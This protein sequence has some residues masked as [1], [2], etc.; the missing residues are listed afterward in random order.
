MANTKHRSDRDRTLDRFVTWG[1]I[2]GALLGI[3]VFVFVVWQQVVAPPENEV[4]QLDCVSIP[5]GVIFAVIGGSLGVLV[6]LLIGIVAWKIK[7]M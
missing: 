5:L 6:G 1:I 7:K 3:A 4:E 2:I